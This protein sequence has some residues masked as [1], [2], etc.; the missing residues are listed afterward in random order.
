MQMHMRMGNLHFCHLLKCVCSY[1]ILTTSPLFPVRQLA[2]LEYATLCRTHLAAIKAGRNFYLQ[3]TFVIAFVLLLAGAALNDEHNEDARTF[4]DYCYVV[5][6]G[7]F[8]GGGV[9]SLATVTL[10]II[11]YITA[12][13][14]KNSAAWGPQNQSIAMAQPQYGQSNS[15]PVFVPEHVYPQYTESQQL[16]SLGGHVQRSPWK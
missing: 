7:V 10:G 1:W 6:S 14:V 5:K 3:I 2:T 11:Y 9:L 4:G 8:A 15:Q 16:P 13:A 12:A